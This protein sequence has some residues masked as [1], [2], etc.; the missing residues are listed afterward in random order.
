M[1][2]YVSFNWDRPTEFFHEGLVIEWA[3]E[4][5]AAAA[6]TTPAAPHTPVPAASPL[7]VGLALAFAGAQRP[8]RSSR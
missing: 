3:W 2:P 6:I 1:I 8:T 4:K 5:V 7:L